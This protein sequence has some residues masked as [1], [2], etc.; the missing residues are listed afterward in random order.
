MNKSDEVLTIGPTLHT[1]HAFTTGRAFIS[2]QS[3]AQPAVLLA[4]V[5]TEA[6]HLVAVFCSTIALHPSKIASKLT[7]RGKLSVSK[8]QYGLNTY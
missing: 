2:T 5:G 1:H 7:K 3:G 4:I 8:K 6:S